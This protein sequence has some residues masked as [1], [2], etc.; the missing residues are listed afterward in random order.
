MDDFL[1]IRLLLFGMA[2]PSSLWQAF[3]DT[4]DVD[5]DF[6]IVKANQ[7]SNRNAFL[8]RIAVPPSDIILGAIRTFEVVIVGFA[9]VGTFGH[10]RGL[11]EVFPV[12]RSLW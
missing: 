11:P 10:H 6:L 2:V 3:Q 8:S 1:K 7:S 9:L 4:I 5:I 12:D